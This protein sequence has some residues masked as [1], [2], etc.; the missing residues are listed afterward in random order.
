VFAGGCAGPLALGAVADGAGYP[1]M[2]VTGAAAMLGAA[3]LMVL[4]GRMLSS[5]GRR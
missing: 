2:W 5:S 4:G 1:A 3:A